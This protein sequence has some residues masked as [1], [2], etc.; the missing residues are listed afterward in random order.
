MR[1]TYRLN[2]FAAFAQTD[3][4][5][6]SLVQS[7]PLSSSLYEPVITPV[8]G[9]LLVDPGGGSTT[10]AGTAYTPAGAAATSSNSILDAISGI[11][12]GL[13]KTAAQAAVTSINQPAKTKTGAAPS[14]A[15]GGSALSSISPAIMIGA[16]VAALALLYVVVRK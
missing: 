4:A 12:A 15:G 9:S 10:L 16:G 8:A 1:G 11:V 6:F 7:D 2:S 13:G 14:V 5:G 3:D